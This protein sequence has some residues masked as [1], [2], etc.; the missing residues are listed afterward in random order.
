MNPTQRTPTLR[1]TFCGSHQVQRS[2]QRPLKPLGQLINHQEIVQKI[3]KE[4]GA[5]SEKTIANT[6]TVAGSIKPFAS[7]RPYSVLRASIPLRPVYDAA[8]IP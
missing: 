8:L 4:V 6:V 1:T 3:P 7:Y 2:R 5:N